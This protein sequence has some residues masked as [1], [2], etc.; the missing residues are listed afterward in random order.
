MSWSDNEIDDFVRD[1]VNNHSVPAYEDAFFN[2]FEKMLPVKKKKRYGFWYLFSAV[3]LLGVSVTAWLVSSEEGK[4]KS[5]IAYNKA[6]ISSNLEQNNQVQKQSN[7]LANQT[8]SIVKPHQLEDQQ[9]QLREPEIK[10]IVDLHL[11]D[12]L[13]VKNQVNPKRIKSSKLLSLPQRLNSVDEVS[14]WQ[15]DQTNIHLDNKELILPV[16]IQAKP[17]LLSRFRPFPTKKYALYAQLGVGLSEA[18]LQNDNS[19]SPVFGASVELG[20]QHHFKKVSLEMGLRFKQV[21]P[22]EMKLSRTSKIY[23][24]GVD[25]FQQTMDYK[26]ISSIEIPIRLLFKYKNHRVGLGVSPSINLGS[27]IDFTKVKND[28]EIDH[29]KLNFNKV[30]MKNWGMSPE[31]SYQ[32][33]LNHGFEFGVQASVQLVNPLKQDVFTQK[34]NPTPIYGQIQLKKSFNLK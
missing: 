23:G 18:Y 17:Q 32:I 19:K 15:Q 7:N 13:G 25:Y 2:E 26:A 34:N 33:G 16:F 5:Q 29:E 10:Q 3:A 8:P 11:S 4:Q 27:R 31:I 21:R 28:I 30:G 22:K 6:L 12:K 20:Y 9:G 24:F 14:I 1:A